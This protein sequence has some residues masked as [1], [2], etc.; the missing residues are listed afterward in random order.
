MMGLFAAREFTEHWA[1]HLGAAVAGG[2]LGIVVTLLVAVRK[3]G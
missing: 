3:A 2:I 1:L